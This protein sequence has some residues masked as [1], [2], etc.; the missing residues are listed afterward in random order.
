MK[1]RGVSHIEIILSFILFISIV[2][3]VLYF[4]NPGKTQRL[5]QSSITFAESEISGNISAVLDTYSVKIAS[6]AGSIVGVEI[7]S[8]GKKARVED[9]QGNKLASSHSGNM[10]SFDRSGRDIVLIK[11]SEDFEEDNTVP[12]QTLDPTLYQILSSNSEKVLSEKRALGLNKSYFADYK[13]VQENLKL[14]G[15]DFAFALIFSPNDQ[16]IAQNSLPRSIDVLS[17]IKRKSVIRTDGSSAF[18]DFGVKIW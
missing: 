18:A 5:V 1:K 17:T 3:L 15:M 16:I 9:Y 14:T 4:F 8:G 10:V 2:F 6:K 11:F 12:A 13:S 7:P